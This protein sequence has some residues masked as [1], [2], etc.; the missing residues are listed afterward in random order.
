MMAPL[1]GAQH[2][3]SRGLSINGDD[4]Y[5]KRLLEY[6]EE[7]KLRALSYGVGESCDL[8]ICDTCILFYYGKNIVLTHY[9]IYYFTIFYCCDTF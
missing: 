8:R 7:V 6:C 3:C 4:E 5:G 9:F 2:V 1:H